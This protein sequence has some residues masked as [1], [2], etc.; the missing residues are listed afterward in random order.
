MQ[1]NYQGKVIFKH[2]QIRLVASNQASMRP[3]PDWLR[4]RCC[5]YTIG[6]FD[7]N[8]CVKRCP[9]IHKRYGDDEE[10]QVYKRKCKV[11]LNLVCEYYGNR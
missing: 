2:V 11:A 8:L 3:L 6:T 5:I 10:T 9:A 4:E 7:N 1:G